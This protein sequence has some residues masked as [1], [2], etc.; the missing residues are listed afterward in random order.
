MG[1]P[2]IPLASSATQRFVLAA[3]LFSSL[4]INAQQSAPLAWSRIDE[5]CPAFLQAAREIVFYRE[6]ETELVDIG[7]V[8]FDRVGRV[9]GEG[10][11]FEFEAPPFAQDGWTFRLT[12]GR[13]VALGSTGEAKALHARERSP[14]RERVARLRKAD[15][16]LAAMQRAVT[17]QNRAEAVAVVEA[18]C[19]ERRGALGANHAL[20]A[21]CEIQHATRALFHARYDEGLRLASNAHATFSSIAPGE[22][23]V[24]ALAARNAQAQAFF[25]LS[26]PAEMHAAALEAFEGRRRLLGAS[27]PDTILSQGAVAIALRRLG[28][29]DDSIPIYEEVARRQIEIHGA[30]GN[31]CAQSQ[32]ESIE[33]RCSNV[34]IGIEWLRCRARSMKPAALNIGRNARGH[35]EFDP[36]PGERPL[37][38]RSSPRGAL[39]GRAARCRCSSAHLGDEHAQTMRIKSLLGVIY[40]DLGRDDESLPLFRDVYAVNQRTFGD[41]HRST[42]LAARNLAHSLVNLG[43]AEESVALT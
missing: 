23:G 29:L 40:L 28:R 5:A 22:R 37:G 15:A 20:V 27:H 18:A 33:L 24:E 26:R 11:A 19:E 42:A 1:L 16:S 13:C 32:V 39:L 9:E 4:A 31:R 14:F 17:A 41:G 3:A 8:R 36:R 30:N 12:S 25:Y 6:A 2:F 21:G 38:C 10:I 43:R 34:V 35:L 7:G